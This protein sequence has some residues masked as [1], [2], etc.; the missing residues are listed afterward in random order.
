MYVLL[1]HLLKDNEGDRN[2]FIRL[3]DIDQKIYLF[4]DSV[5]LVK[6]S[7]I[8]CLTGKNLIFPVLISL[9]VPSKLQQIL[10]QSAAK[11]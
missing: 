10:A 1:K 6:I 8:I 11:I 4:L 3:P 2:P 7:E 5:H 9:L